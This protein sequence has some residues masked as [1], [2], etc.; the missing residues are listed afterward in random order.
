MQIL[1]L[2]KFSK[3]LFY[4]FRNK[5]FL[6][7][8]WSS[9]IEMQV[10]KMSSNFWVLITVDIYLLFCDLDREVTTSVLIKGF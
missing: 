10:R 6:F 5:L 1:H 3:N 9:Y 2:W 8:K 4:F 7:I